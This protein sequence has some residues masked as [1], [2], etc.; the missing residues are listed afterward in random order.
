MSKILIFV[1]LI[2]IAVVPMYGQNKECILDT[3]K[4]GD[5]IKVHAELLAEMRIIPTSCFRDSR[6]SILLM[7]ED[8]RPFWKYLLSQSVRDFFHQQGYERSFEESLL[9]VKQNRVFLEFKR[10]INETVPDTYV[11]KQGASFIKHHCLHCGKYDITAEFEGMLAILP[12]PKVIK[13][14]AGSVEGIGTMRLSVRY[15]LILT[16]ILS[17]EAVELGWLDSLPKDNGAGGIGV[18]PTGKIIRID[19]QTE[20]EQ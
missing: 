15:V 8:T 12:S 10:L 13:P 7:W 20:T 14:G 4:D 19:S 5:M 2:L 18:G 3:A 1:V 16:S 6:N 9:P 11:E 17:L